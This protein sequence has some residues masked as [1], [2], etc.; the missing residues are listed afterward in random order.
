MIQIPFPRNPN[1]PDAI[2]NQTVNIDTDVLKQKLG[3]GF[4]RNWSNIVVAGGYPLRSLFGESH[5]LSL[6]SDIDF[7]FVFPSGTAPEDARQKMVETIDQIFTTIKNNPARY[8]IYIHRSRMGNLDFK[9]KLGK[10]T[11]YKLQFVV[12]TW[13][14]SVESI[15]DSFDLS[16]CKFAWDGTKLHYTKD[17]EDVL[18]HQTFSAL[19]ES[20]CEYLDSRIKKYECRGFKFGWTSLALMEEAKRPYALL[21]QSFFSSH[22]L[23]NMPTNAADR[24]KGLSL[25]RAIPIFEA[26]Q[27]IYATPSFDSFVTLDLAKATE[28]ATELKVDGWDNLVSLSE[29]NAIDHVRKLMIIELGKKRRALSEPEE[30]NTNRCVEA[31][32]TQPT[33]PVQPAEVIEELEALNQQIKEKLENAL[34]AN[35]PTNSSVLTTLSQALDMFIGTKKEQGVKKRLRE[36]PTQE[37]E[38]PKKVSK[39]D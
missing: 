15:L 11:A 23:N 10:R 3:L 13:Y 22:Y 4:V 16:C 25:S 1:F 2:F 14:E 19:K 32:T 28:W 31:Q 34:S 7:F 9:V 27:S 24:V 6:G 20:E 36:E 38:Q 5:D 17:A 8:R 30:T 35:N 26:L 37:D 21:R 33:Q 12:T 18:T 29:A 39:N